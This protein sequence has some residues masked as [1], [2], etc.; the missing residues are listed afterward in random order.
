ME[1]YIGSRENIKVLHV[2][3]FCQMIYQNNFSSNYR[4]IYRVETKIKDFT[5]EVKLCQTSI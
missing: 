2:K 5:S 1:P 4:A 3:F